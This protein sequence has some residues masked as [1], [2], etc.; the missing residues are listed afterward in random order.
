MQP[1]VIAISHNADIDG[2]GCVA[3]LKTKYRIND[4]DIFL[5]NYGR[6]DLLAVERA[7]KKAKPKN[8][9][10]FISDLGANDDKL[11]LFLSIIN[12]VKKGGGKA[13]WF[14]HHIWSKAALQ[15]LSKRCD[16]IV[17]AEKLCASE[18]TI[19]Q[20]G[21]K[22]KFIKEFKRVCHASDFNLQPKDRRS[23]FLIKTYAMGIA[24]Y[25][26][27]PKAAA[28]RKL[29]AFAKTLASGSLTNKDIISEAKKFEEISNK[30]IRVMVKD[31]SLIGD[32]IAVGFAK[33][34]QS[35]NACYHIIKSSGR[36][37][38]IFINMDSKKGNIRSLR[39]NINP[40]AASMGGGG[41]PHAS[42]FSFGKEYNI[43]T[44]KG[45][46]KLLD[47]IDAEAAKLKI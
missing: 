20:L 4:S 34:L 24:A 37:I 41:H 40:L 38:G 2:I 8:A 1:R 21:L 33:S 35:T 17:R 26:V 23:Q 22:G 45:R 27:K 7:I 39:S 44:Q 18:V 5:I 15:K 3:M 29:K 13:F 16:R 14:D 43:S 42:G 6:D 25:N 9:H 36:E 12:T 32:K 47:K 30:R 31:L 11:D 19:A 46:L 10:L 28:Q